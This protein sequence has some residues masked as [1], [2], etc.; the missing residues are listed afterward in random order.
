MDGAI[1]VQLL[2]VSGHLRE[3]MTEVDEDI[4]KRLIGS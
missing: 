1:Q 4:A 2:P 3:V